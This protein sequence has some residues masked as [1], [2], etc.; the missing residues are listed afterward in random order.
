VAA[1]PIA[2]QSRI[3]KKSWLEDVKKERI[4][5]NKAKE[6]HRYGASKKSKLKLR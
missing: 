6:R 4:M 2:S 5:V 1:V 3:K